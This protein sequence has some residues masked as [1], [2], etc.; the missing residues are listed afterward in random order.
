MIIFSLQHPLVTFFKIKFKDLSERRSK[1][2]G[3]A[4]G[5][6]DVLSAA[7]CL[8]WAV[9]IKTSDEV[10]LCHW[11]CKKT[12]FYFFAWMCIPAS[13]CKIIKVHSCMAKPYRTYKRKK[14]QKKHLEQ[15]NMG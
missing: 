11:F 10:K 4:I 12:H 3:Y 6:D 2:D 8:H 9:C 7:H 1:F 13:Q 15:Y 5:L 14:K